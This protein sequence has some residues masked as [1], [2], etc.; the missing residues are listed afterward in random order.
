MELHGQFHHLNPPQAEALN[1]FFPLL[2]GG[3]GS[4]RV[5]LDAMEISGNI[6]GWDLEVIPDPNED[7]YLSTEGGA[8]P[9]WQ[10]AF[11]R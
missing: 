8:T 7:V 9:I 4:Q 1:L 6:C 3:P 2:D 11:G 5:L 10:E